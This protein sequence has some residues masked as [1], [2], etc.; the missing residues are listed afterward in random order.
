MNSMKNALR[1][2]SPIIIYLC[3]EQVVGFLINFFYTMSIYDSSKEW[4]QEVENE[5]YEALYDMLS[6][7]MILITGVISAICLLIFYIMMNREWRK[8][9]YYIE[10]TKPIYIKYLYVAAASVGLTVAA[11][12]AINAFEVFSYAGDY[13]QIADVLYSEPLYLQILIIGILAPVC[14]ELMFR[15]LIYERLS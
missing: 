14:E 6:K 7:N 9:T 11:N 3:V 15:G 8:R 4:S 5:L 13:T 12:L 2:I 1:V 10:E